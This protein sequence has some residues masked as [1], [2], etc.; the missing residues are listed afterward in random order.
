MLFPFSLYLFTEPCFCETFGMV[1]IIIRNSCSFSNSLFADKAFHNV[2]FLT[3]A[4]I[5]S[6]ESGVSFQRLQLQPSET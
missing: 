5:A 1:A 3:K 4:F 6:T 2:I